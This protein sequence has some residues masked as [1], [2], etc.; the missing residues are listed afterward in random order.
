ML[1]RETNKDAGCIER[2]RF[3]MTPLY[4]FAEHNEAFYYYHKAKFEGYMR[5]PMD[6][7]HIDAHNDM[8]FPRVFKKSIYYSAQDPKD[9]YLEYFEDFAKREL[10]ISNFILPA[11]LSGLISNVYFIYPS[12]RRMKPGRR[13][14]NIASCFGEGRILKRQMGPEKSLT[15]GAMLKALPDLKYFNYSAGGIENVPKNRKVI[16]DI[17]F[18]YFAC[19]DSIL[20]EI[21]YELE[22]TKEQF[23]NKV[24]LLCD[25]TL[26][27][28]GLDFCFEEKNEKYYA[29]I[30]HKKSEDMAYL[31]SRENI[32]SEINSLVSILR[33]KRIKP[34]V[35]TLC[36]SSI[37]GY[38]PQ[39]YVEFIEDKLTKRLMAAFNGIHIST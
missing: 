1:K 30:A 18:D 2:R 3:Q 10:S 22:I 17:D 34:V 20:N 24:N 27:F 25:K 33:D 37:S 12:W 21:N 23:L 29:K 15:P 5:R 19:R 39:D 16:L 35:V 26:R 4:L 13:K 31:P 36:R 28:S 8:G 6:L 32:E 9:K 7:F 14:M 38:C 11:V